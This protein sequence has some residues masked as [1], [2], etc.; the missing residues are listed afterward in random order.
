M[1]KTIHP[2]GKTRTREHVLADLGVNHLERHVLLCGYTLHRVLSDYGYDLVLTTYRKSGEIE[3]GAVY[4]QVKATSR[5]PLRKNGKTIS[6][7]VSRRDLKLWL[8][9]AYPVILVVYDGEHDQAYWISIQEY[10]LD[11]PREDLFSARD[12]IR[13][14]IPVTNTIDRRSIDFIA[15]QKRFIHA[16]IRGRN[17]PHV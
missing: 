10:F 13:V 4:V 5:L 17:L 15:D 14:A 8:E 9:E 11:L 12:T 6:W 3:P 1:A 16:R 7:P 2:R